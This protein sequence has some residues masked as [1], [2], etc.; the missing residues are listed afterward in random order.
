MPMTLSPWLLF[1]S[2][3]DKSHHMPLNS[4]TT[5]G[6]IAHRSAINTYLWHCLLTYL[7]CVKTPVGKEVEGTIVQE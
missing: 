1:K 3:S 6:D 7:T 4:L 2:Q 5:I